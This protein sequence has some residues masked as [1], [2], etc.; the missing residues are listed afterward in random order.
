MASMAT[1]IPDL[2]DVA[3]NAEA[4]R[5]AYRP[6]RIAVLFVQM[7]LRRLNPYLMALLFSLLSAG[8][9]KALVSCSI[10]T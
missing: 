8:P 1:P 2:A 5:A 3:A 7:R 6:D 4:L 10:R 9:M